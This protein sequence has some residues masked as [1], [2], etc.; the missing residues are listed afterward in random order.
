MFPYHT[1]RTIQGIPYLAYRYNRGL[2]ESR[3][4][5]QLFA[6]IIVST[7]AQM[8]ATKT[9]LLS[10]FSESVHA[11]VEITRATVMT[12][13]CISYANSSEVEIPSNHDIVTNSNNV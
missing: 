7:E 11:K 3:D 6:Q 2:R 12:A 10:V 1:F 9:A 5:G 8:L 13:V 4:L